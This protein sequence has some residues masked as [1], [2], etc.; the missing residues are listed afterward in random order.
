[1]PTSSL[2]PARIATIALLSVLLLL[3][4]FGIGFLLDDYMLLAAVED[5]LAGRGPEDGLFTFITGDP[6]RTGELAR[7]GLYPWWIQDDVRFAFFRPLSSALVRLDHAVFVGN[8]IGYHVHSLAW[9]LALLVAVAAVL[10]RTLPGSIAATA[11]AVFAIDESHLVPAG[12]ISNRNAVVALAPAFFGMWAHMRW[13]EEGWRPGRF[14]GLAGFAVGLL[15]GEVGLSALGY[16]IAYEVVTGRGGP[17]ARAR[18]AAPFVALGVAYLVVYVLG[19][20]GAAGSGIYLDPIGAPLEFL[21]AAPG[22]LLALASGGVLGFS[23]DT[24]MLGGAWRRALTG[25]GIAALL[26]AAALARLVSSRL[27][28]PARRGLWW[29]LAGAALAVAPTLATFPSD[30]L[31]L[32]SMPGLAGLLGAALVLGFDAWRSRRRALVLA[33]TALLASI[34]LVLAPL[35]SLAT[36][37]MLVAESRASRDAARS[38]V[39]R[40]ARGKEVVILLAPDHEI[41]FY[42]PLV[43]DHDRTFDHRGWRVLSLA[44]HDHVLS[45]PSSRTLRLDVVEGAMMGSL[46]EVLYRDRAH[47]LVAGTVLERGLFRVEILADAGGKPTRVAFHFDRDLEDPSIAFVEWRDGALRRAA[48]PAVGETRLLRRSPGPTG[49]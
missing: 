20:Y 7:R 28:P 46:F 8:P 45:R 3:P 30:R 49:F 27:D 24:W 44:P 10:R 19:G 25:F 16:P 13:R 37:A 23:A 9:W 15:G 12:W 18:G 21:R 29:L 41:A 38:P 17:L 42:V 4:S 22:R 43:M 14:L 34:H 5:R 26:A 36:Q 32:A 11:L 31:M 1:M 47:P 33:G 48:L 35:A 6:A 2:T 39:L 40:E